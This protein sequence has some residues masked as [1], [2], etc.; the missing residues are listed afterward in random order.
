SGIV[1]L[2]S[3][4]RHRALAGRDGS[5]RLLYSSRTWEAT[6]YRDELGHLARDDERLVVL[7]TLTRSAPP[8]WSGLT[9][10]VDRPMLEV[11][12]IAPSET[13]DVFVCGPTPFVESVASTLVELGHA[14]ARIRTERFG[15]TGGPA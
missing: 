12:A 3:M 7:H 5:A 13:P 10:R 11:H 6:I 2:M 4:L 14:P 15:P 9:R 1:P 8:G